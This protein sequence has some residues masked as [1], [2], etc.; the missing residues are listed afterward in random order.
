[1]PTAFKTFVIITAALTGLVLAVNRPAGAGASNAAVLHDEK[2]PSQ[3]MVA[4]Q[5]PPRS[6]TPETSPPG[7]EST[8]AESQ[9]REKQN[10]A[11]AKEKPLEEFQPS[12]KIDADQ[13]VDFPYDI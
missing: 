6:A 13:G 9:T 2:Q 10:S 4:G 1:M 8:P 11:A 5:S 3:A 12:E 7:S